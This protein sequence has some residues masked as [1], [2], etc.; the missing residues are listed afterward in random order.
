MRALDAV[1][2]AIRGLAVDRIV[3]LGD[4]VGYN[5]EPV[6]V[7]DA[8]REV[9][10]AVVVGNHEVDVVRDSASA[11]TRSAARRAQ[12]WTREQLDPDRRR[13][14]A[15]LPAHLRDDSGLRLAHGCYL[16][17]HYYTGYVTPTMYGANLDAIADPSAGQQLALC[18]HTHLPFCV[19]ATGDGYAAPPTH[20]PVR[21]PAGAPAVLANPGS[22]GQPRDGDSRACFAVL[23]LDDRTIGWHRVDYDVDGACRAITDAGLD[24]SLAARLREG[25]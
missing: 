8:I 1:L 24:P 18:G 10:D 6:D 21:W 9:A 4:L 23:D 7:I 2:R 11:Y 3:V 17:D 14:L 19:W 25:R 12:N 20:E 16:N 5:A 22:V 15:E 13:Y